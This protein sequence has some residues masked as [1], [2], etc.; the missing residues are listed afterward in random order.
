MKWKK[1]D[2]VWELNGWE[3][4]QSSTYENTHNDEKGYDWKQFTLK[5]CALKIPKYFI[6]FKLKSK[7]PL[8]P[9]LNNF[10]KF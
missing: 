7:T 6:G 8:L 5:A 2:K 4:S 9:S 3:E 1:K 10:A